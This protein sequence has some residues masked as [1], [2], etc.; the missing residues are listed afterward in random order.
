M[1]GVGD[2]DN[3]AEVVVR[4]HQ[5]FAETCFP[6]LRLACLHV[7]LLNQVQVHHAVLTF[8]ALSVIA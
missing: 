1:Q 6:F 2:H 4:I 7:V 3:V 8:S 5:D